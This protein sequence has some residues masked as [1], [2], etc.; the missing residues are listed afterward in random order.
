MNQDELT[1][2]IKVWQRARVQSLLDQEWPPEPFAGESLFGEIRKDFQCW[3]YTNDD[4]KKRHVAT[5]SKSCRAGNSL[6]LDSNLEAGELYF[7]FAHSKS[8]SL[9]ATQFA[10]GIEPWMSANN[11][12]NYEQ[13]TNY[14]C[15]VDFLQDNASNQSYT[16]A[17]TCVRAFKKLK[18]LFDS[19]LMVERIE[20]RQKLVTHLS[21]SA[22]ERDQIQQFNR[23]FL[24]AS[25]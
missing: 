25:L 20:N 1:R 9:T 18:G 15:H 17:T 13:S 12:S 23:K 8:L 2:Q 19:L 24:E 22:L 7:S 14:Q 21:L 11:Q 10:K 6:Y 4:D 16:R 5:A 3:G